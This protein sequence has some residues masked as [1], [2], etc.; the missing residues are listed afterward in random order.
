MITNKTRIIH[1][2]SNYIDGQIQRA[3]DA[4]KLNDEMA[5][6]MQSKKI[7]MLT[8]AEASNE[9]FFDGCFVGTAGVESAAM[10]NAMRKLQ[11]V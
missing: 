4:G 2:I 6:K 7:C 3:T 11:T 1:L 5:A 10:V 8:K 9:E